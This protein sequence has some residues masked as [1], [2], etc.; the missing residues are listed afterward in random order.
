MKKE[1]IA[2][3]KE[4][5]ETIKHRDN[6]LHK[7]QRTLEKEL[8]DIKEER[9]Q[10]EKKTLRARTYNADSGVCPICYIDHGLSSEFKPVPSDTEMDKFRCTHCGYLLEVE[11]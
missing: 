2:L 6:T 10:F 5:I 1:L 9:K 3:L 4:H 11:A 7:K 8:G